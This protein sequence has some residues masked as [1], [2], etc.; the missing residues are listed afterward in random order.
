[1]YAAPLPLSRPWEGRSN[2]MKLL[3]KA[4][5]L[6]ADLSRRQAAFLWNRQKC[7]KE[8]FKN[9]AQRLQ[10]CRKAWYTVGAERGSRRIN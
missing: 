5:S 8:S 3:W 1:M 6:P 7:R 2:F 9:Y 10:K 4:Y